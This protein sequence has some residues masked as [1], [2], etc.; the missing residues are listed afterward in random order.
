MVG[1][2]MTEGISRVDGEFLAW[3]PLCY[4]TPC[5]F[6]DKGDLWLKIGPRADQQTPA[7]KHT[8]PIKDWWGGCVCV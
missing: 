4:F 8:Q 7:I 3:P 1:V 2:S 6:Y 5:S